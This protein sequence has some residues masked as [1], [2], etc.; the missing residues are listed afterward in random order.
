MFNPSIIGLVLSNLVPVY[1]VTF[2]GW[3]FAN[4]I[5]LYWFENV[6]IGIF[7][8]FKMI[9][10]RNFAVTENLDQSSSLPISVIKYFL[11]GFFI[12]HFGVFTLAHGV[13]LSV[14][15]SGK[16]TFHSSLLV[17]IFMMFISHGI[18]F[19]HNYIRPKNYLK[20]SSLL[21]M[22][23]P[24]PRIIVVHLTVIFAG[25]FIID[26][27]SIVPL[28]IFTLL[29]TAVDLGSHLFEHRNSYFNFRKVKKVPSVVEKSLVEVFRESVKGGQWEDIANAMDPKERKAVENFYKSKGVD[30]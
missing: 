17:A 22:F 27:L 3:S 19:V 18:S 9:L 1:G 21:L 7:I 25:L 23:S 20:A 29:K 24:Y 8:V 6:V 2:L 10:V 15:F 4:I 11:I 26:D 16:I 14:I 30:T 13:F 28:I 5:F 12:L